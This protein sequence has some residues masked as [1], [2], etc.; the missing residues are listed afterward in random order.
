VASVVLVSVL[1]VV[2]DAVDVSLLELE[3]LLDEVSVT[4]IDF[5]ASAM[6]LAKSPPSGGG[7]GGR[8]PWVL[9]ALLLA[10]L[11]LTLLVLLRRLRKLSA[12]AALVELRALIDIRFSADLV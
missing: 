8:T 1:S 2:V 5:S 11:L 12:L 7:G 10:L 4:P 6:A 3:L 9:S